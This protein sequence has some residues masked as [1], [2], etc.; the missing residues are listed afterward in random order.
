[1]C[2]LSQHDVSDVMCVIYHSF[3]AARRPLWSGIV[4][5]ELGGC[6]HRPSSDSPGRM[7]GAQRGG[8]FEH[9]P[10]PNPFARLKW[11]P[12]EL[13]L[14]VQGQQGPQGRGVACEGGVWNC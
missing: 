4:R 14:E 10:F 9:N 3:E 12:K 5:G 11:S 1:M 13:G 8:I 6:C 7:A 2:G